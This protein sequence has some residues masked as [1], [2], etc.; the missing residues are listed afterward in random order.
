VY[1]H[2]PSLRLFIAL[3]YC[4]GATLLAVALAR[5][6]PWLG[7]ELAPG[8]QQ[9][10]HVVRSQAPSPPL[11]VGAQLL[12]LG[13]PGS[14]AMPVQAQDLIEDPDALASY[15]QMDDF[16]D[17]QGRL[18]RVLQSPVV[19][20]S[21]RATP[22]AEPVLTYV[23][24]QRR[25]LRSLPAVFWFQAAVSTLGCLI[26][27]WVWALRPRDW[28]ATLFGVTG[29]CFPLFAM[30]A[31]VY[32]SRELALP[33]GL[34]S[35]LSAINLYGAAL[36]GA[37]LVG[38][39]LVHPRPLVRPAWL[40]LPLAGFSLWWWADLLRLPPSPDLGM[41]L[42]VM[43][44]MLLAAA[45]AGVQWR[46]TRGDALGR[47]ALRWLSLS[48]LVG[49]GLFI[50]LVIATTALGW[51][52]AVP[53]GYAF[54]F[55]LFIYVGIALGLR[56]HRLFELDEWALRM[57]LWVGGALALV[58]VDAALIALL[59]WSSTAALG[60]SLWLC[61]VLYFPARQWLWQRLAPDPRQR[62]QDAMPDVVRI[63]LQ[64]SRA[65]QESLWDDLLRR[66][67]APL[68]LQSSG[69]QEPG[70]VQVRDDGLALQV[71]ACGGM[72]G[73]LMRYPAQ[74]RRLFSSKD[75][76]FLDALCQLMDQARA[77]RT[78]YE[79]GAREERQ[80]IARDMHDDVG[81]R[82]LMLI[83]RASSPELAEL[84][85]AAMHD[86]RTA[87]H[88]MDVCDAPLAD[89]LGDWRAEA[90]A[91]CEAAGADLHWSTD[92][93]ASARELLLP[94]RHRAALERVLR[95]GL[96]NA[97]RH[98][99]PRRVSVTIA[100]RPGDVLDIQLRHDGDVGEPGNWPAGRGLSGMR[101]RLIPYDG[102]LHIRQAQDGWAE[103]S[104]RLPLSVP[105]D[106]PRLS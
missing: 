3:G 5:Q 62:I 47:A 60:V 24:P 71:P 69:P 94:A 103:L 76:T 81:A 21:W 63:A 87:L 91:R 77:G 52:P 14:P 34:F 106:L 48:M 8:P 35:T 45:L 64:P 89:A 42:A 44:E 30:P 96:S 90:E 26:A 101:Q 46:R 74:G 39:F 11:P 80:R 70:G 102:Q 16:F 85:R 13:L 18:A 104:I 20:V 4:L 37:A 17:R 7:L 55:F 67:Y 12:A 58:A 98:A 95:E 78:A 75:I 2:P 93:P 82:L 61:G 19:A 99:R 9:Q 84:A 15:A 40:A 57:L 31:A 86:L 10:V 65:R 50:T 88:T 72:Q 33:Q 79:L 1:A 83:H 105:G 38:I 66:L 27:C 100:L 92:D 22:G 28:G 53:Q 51:L 49:S 25:P 41:R 56:R 43:I 97:L 68:D 73:R 54:G 32:S 6:L 29:L 23:S 36:F 59:D